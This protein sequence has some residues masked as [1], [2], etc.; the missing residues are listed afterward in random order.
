MTGGQSAVRLNDGH[1]FP[2]GGL[3]ELSRATYPP[4]TDARSPT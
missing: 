4:D 1:S 2:M 3:V